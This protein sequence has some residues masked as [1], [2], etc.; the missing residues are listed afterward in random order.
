MDNLYGNMHPFTC[1]FCNK[2]INNDTEYGHVSSCGSVLEPCINK[3][4][5][6]VPRN[7]KSRHLKECKNRISKSMTKLSFDD[8]YDTKVLE[9]PLHNPGSTSSLG[10]FKNKPNYSQSSSLDFTQLSSKYQHLDH[11]CKQLSQAVYALKNKHQE[12]LQAQQHHQMQTKMQL[13]KIHY[14]N[15]I[16]A[17]WKRNIEMQTENLKLE[18]RAYQKFQNESEIRLASV[19][20]TQSI[21]E[22]MAVDL[23]LLKGQFHEEQLKNREGMNDLQEKLNEFK[24]YF[25]QENA[26]VGALWNDHKTNI[27]KL[28]QEI[29]TINKALDEHK[30]KQSSINFDV[31]TANQISAET[32]DKLEIQERTLGDVIK[33]LAQFKIDLRSLEE[34]S[35]NKSDQIAGHLL[36]KITDFALKMDMAKENDTV[37]KSPVFYTHDYGYKVRLQIYLNGIKKWKGRHMIACIH[38]LKGEYDLLLKWPCFI[39]GTMVLRDLYNY[40]NPTDFSKYISAKR[41][42]GDEENEEPQESSAQYIFIPHTTLT[43]QNFIKED[44][45]FLDLRINS[46]NRLRDETEL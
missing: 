26:V 14:Q 18:M 43:K 8:S 21:T 4:G 30:A 20:S 23:N 11:I 33:E 46:V 9:Q 41:H 15:Q 13:E 22:K 38:V 5:L 28:L 12:G 3:C 39:E 42:S 6:Y 7:M 44:T 24:D 10:R 16:L 29:S 37:L 31:R 34:S 17:E 35:L 36:W 45:L 27:N 32:S 25:A 1:Y 40:T 19:K 2:L